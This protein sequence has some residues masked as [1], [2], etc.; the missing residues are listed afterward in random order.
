MGYRKGKDA[1]L[2]QMAMFLGEKAKDTGLAQEIGPL[3]PYERRIV[4]LAVAETRR[5]SPRR[6]SA[7]RSRRPSSSRQ[8]A[9]SRRRDL[10]SRLALELVP[11]PVF[12]F[13]HHRR[14]RHPAGPR[15]P[16]C[17]SA[18]RARCRAHRRSTCRPRN[19]RFAAA[20]RDVLPASASRHSERSRRSRGHDVS[21][22]ALLHRRRRRRNLRARQSGGSRRHPASG[23]RRP[24]RGWRSPASSRC[25]PF[26]TASSIWSRRRRSRDLIDAVTPLQA[27]A[28]FDQLEGT[29]TT[30][31]AAIETELFD[32]VAR[33]EASLDFPDEGYHFVDAGEAQAALDAVVTS[34]RRAAGQCRARPPGSRRRAWSRSSARR[35][36]ASR[37][38]STRS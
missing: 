33:L 26:F 25:A 36:S 4:H 32:L 5:R 12:H 37:A 14:D 27:R 9:G 29:L 22:A 16:R 28:A 15:R 10:L 18:E 8:V 7:T 38:C 23:D 1:E 34:A 3:N 21:G 2:Q 6:A 20:A 31:I 35:T 30:A 24:A 13:R 17:R 19:R 11:A